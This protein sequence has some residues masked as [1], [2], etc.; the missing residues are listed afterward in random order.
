MSCLHLLKLDVAGPN[1]IA[2]TMY[3]Q[4]L[5]AQIFTFKLKIHRISDEILPAPMV[6]RLDAIGLLIL[7]FFLTPIKR[8]DKRLL[9]SWRK[10]DA[11]QALRLFDGSGSLVF[12]ATIPRKLLNTYPLAVKCCD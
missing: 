9:R 4:H 10:N 11:T 1:N 5:Q 12:P 6:K 3:H 8:L 2:F 7:L